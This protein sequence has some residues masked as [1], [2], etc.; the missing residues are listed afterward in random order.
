MTT[1]AQACK[2]LVIRARA[3]DQ[4]AM[5]MIF[6]VGNSARNGSRT[7][8]QS[9][10]LIEE[11]C[12]KNP[13]PEPMQ[14][15]ANWSDLMQSY[16]TELQSSFSGEELGEYVVVLLPMMGQFGINTLANGPTISNDII[17]QIASE[18]G[19]E[20]EQHAFQFAVF[21]ADQADKIKKNIANLNEETAYAVLLGCCVGEAKNI[22]QVRLPGASVSLISKKAAE[23]FG[24][25]C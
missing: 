2:E 20:T 8:I 6:E 16:I 4:N 1:I 22:Q 9:A 15:N 14:H 23:E 18:F 10:K 25:S 24:E 7:A 12:E 19:S 5:A 17:S 3:G 21:H 13:P 11:Y